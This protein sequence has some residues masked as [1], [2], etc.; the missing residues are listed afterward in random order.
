MEE[1]AAFFLLVQPFH[2]H[3]W[4]AP[5]VHSEHLIRGPDTPTRGDR[6]SQGAFS[7]RVDIR[8]ETWNA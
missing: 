7:I 6:S 4:L 8:P 1:A 2:P 3:D 5:L